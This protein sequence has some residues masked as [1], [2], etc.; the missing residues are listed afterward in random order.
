MTTSSNRP[1][2]PSCGVKVRPNCGFTPNYFAL[3]RD[4]EYADAHRLRRCD[5]IVFVEPSRGDVVKNAGMLEVFPLRLRHPDILGP[6]ARKI[7]LDADELL[8]LRIGERTQ[9]RGI[10]DGENRGIGANAQGHGQ[11]GDRREARRFAQGTKGVPDVLRQT[12]P[13]EP[14]TGFVEVL[15]GVEFIAKGAPCSGAGFRET[16]SS[17]AQVFGFKLNVLFDF[18]V[19]IVEFALAPQ[20]RYYPSAAS[21]PKIRAIALAK[22]FHLVVSLTSCL[23]PKTVSE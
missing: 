2:E 16:H 4:Q 10:D 6:D 5:E 11:D 17:L 15:F 3:R 8:G 20:H 13:P 1:G 12:I 18:S 19:E 9:Q 21:E 7:V 23:R 22:R 14:A